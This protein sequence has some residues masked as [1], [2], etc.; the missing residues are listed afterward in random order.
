MKILALDVAGAATGWA[1]GN[2]HSL[3]A[4]GKFISDLKQGRGERLC[5][6]SVF[7]RDLLVLYEPDVILI[8]RPYLGRN[9]NVLVNLSKMIAAVE[10]QAFAVL[11]INIESEWFISPREVKK[12]LEIYPRPNSRNHDDTYASNKAATV[13]R[14]NKLFGLSLNYTKNKSKKFNDDDIA[15]AIAVL[16]TWWAKQKPNE[17]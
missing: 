16:A 14:I 1:F 3:K 8:E 13:A 17:E 12:V 9:S 7:I 6:F 15:D 10:I 11:G 5:S 4:Y 2:N